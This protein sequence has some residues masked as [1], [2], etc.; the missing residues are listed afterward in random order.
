M[1]WSVKTSVAF[2]L[3]VIRHTCHSVASHSQCSIAQSA[4]IRDCCH[5]SDCCVFCLSLPDF[6][7][8][9][10]L[11]THQEGRRKK[12]VLDF[13]KKK[14]KPLFGH[15]SSKIAF[16]RSP[17]R[18]LA[19]LVAALL[20]MHGKH[21]KIIKKPILFLE[22]E[23]FIA[24]PVSSESSRKQAWTCQ[25][26]SRRMAVQKWDCSAVCREVNINDAALHS[27]RVITS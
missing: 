25:R 10:R 15:A 26:L 24:L 11:A 7:L 3:T 9:A 5:H 18:L 1:K 19:L 20:N 8:V 22:L 12:G 17:K 23:I 14:K 27:V 16:N 13:Q 2:F 4:V 6:S 21:P